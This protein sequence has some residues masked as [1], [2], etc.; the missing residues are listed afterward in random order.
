MNRIHSWGLLLNP[1]IWRWPIFCWK[2]SPQRFLLIFLFFRNNI[3]YF[4]IYSALNTRFCPII[5]R[6]HVLISLFH[7]V[8]TWQFKDIIKIFLHRFIRP[9]TRGFV[10]L[11]FNV[12]EAASWLHLLTKF[13][14]A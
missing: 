8:E 1:N 2:E 10:P 12:F 4:Y 11:F 5:F 13:F 14:L 3:R 7:S 6:R 9:Y